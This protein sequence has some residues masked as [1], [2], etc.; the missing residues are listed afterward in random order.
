MCGL[1]LCA[2]PCFSYLWKVLSGGQ[3]LGSPCFPAPSAPP[4]WCRWKEA[5]MCPVHPGV[6]Y[7]GHT[8]LG[9]SLK[10][11]KQTRPVGRH[12][13]HLPL[14]PE[15]CFWNIPG[16]TPLT[17]ALAASLGHIPGPPDPPHPQGPPAPSLIHNLFFVTSS[18]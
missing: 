18:F 2:R 5:G 14:Q 3:G 16:L 15:T 17:P 1:V 7:G 11:S 6:G 8:F 12:T 9:G 4:A 10:I 13:V